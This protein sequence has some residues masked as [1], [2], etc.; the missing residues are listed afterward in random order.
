[1]AKRNATNS[2]EMAKMAYKVAHFSG[3]WPLF[4]CH[5]PRALPLTSN[6]CATGPRLICISWQLL[7]GIISAR[8]V[9][10]FPVDK[11]YGEK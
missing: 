2:W 6:L 3:H 11:E 10:V 4:I 1:M 8:V 5:S 9:C 7:L